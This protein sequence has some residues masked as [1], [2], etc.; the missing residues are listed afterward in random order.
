MYGCQSVEYASNA[1]TNTRSKPANAAA[2]T[3]DAMNAT[4]GVGAPW[5]TSGVHEWNGTAATL[6]PN[7][8]SRSP[9]PASSNA[10][11]CVWPSRAKLV[12]AMRVRLVEPVEPYTNAMPYRKN[13]DENAPS[14]KYFTPASC[15]SMRRRC[16]DA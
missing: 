11:G 14:T 3:A 10:G 8:T 2:F 4:T 15:D 16:I 9:K 6:K 12:S 13:A 5:Y 7:P 1:S